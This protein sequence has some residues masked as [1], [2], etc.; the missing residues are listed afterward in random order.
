MVISIGFLLPSSSTPNQ[1]LLFGTPSRQRLTV[2]PPW[3]C[4]RVNPSCIAAWHFGHVIV[5]FSPLETRES[6]LA[7]VARLSEVRSREPFA[8]AHNKR[9][10]W[11]PDGRFLTDGGVAREPTLVSI[12]IERL[13]FADTSHRQVKVGGGIDLT[14]R[15]L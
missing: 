9:R 12:G 14:P 5:S 6:D 10:D 3:T 11:L 7:S 2:F 8:H 15:F 4:S 13:D 1:R